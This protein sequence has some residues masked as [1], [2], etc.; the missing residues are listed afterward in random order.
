MLAPENGHHSIA[1]KLIDVASLGNYLLHYQVEV[2]IKQAYHI[3]GNELLGQRSKAADIKKNNRGFHGF[4]GQQAIGEVGPGHEVEH[5]LIDVHLQNVVFLNGAQRFVQLPHLVGGFFDG[6]FQVGKIDG[7]HHEVE[8]SAVHG[9]AQVA[10]VAIGRYDDRFHGRIFGVGVREQGQPVHHGHVDVA[11]NDVGI[12]VFR[13]ALQGFLPVVG[14][15]KLVGAFADF[16]PKL[17][18]DEQLEVGFVVDHQY[19]R[20]HVR[21]VFSAYPIIDTTAG[22][23]EAL[24]AHWLRGSAGWP[25]ARRAAVAA[26]F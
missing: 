5:R 10:Q 4:A 26:W 19:F 24:L 23:G 22:S 7:L 11:E 8:G 9:R 14:K 1:H 12:G 15:N 3:G 6:D 13:D 20:F 17:L 18:L 2:G 16:A 21:T 25:F